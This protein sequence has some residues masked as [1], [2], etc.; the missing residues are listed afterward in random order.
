MTG[1]SDEMKKDVPDQC[2]LRW[3]EFLDDMKP[4]D[5]IGHHDI[6]SPVLL[7]GT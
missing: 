1:E 3:K 2:A 5:H 4:G 6:P 7:S